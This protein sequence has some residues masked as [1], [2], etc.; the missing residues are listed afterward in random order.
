MQIK[1]QR[2]C[3]YVLCRVEKVKVMEA[4]LSSLYSFKIKKK[5][6]QVECQVLTQNQRSTSEIQGSQ[7]QTKSLLKNAMF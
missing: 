1:D 6:A 5:W 3:A 7:V 4:V 2:S